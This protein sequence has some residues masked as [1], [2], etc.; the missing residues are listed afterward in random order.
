MVSVEARMTSGCTDLPGYGA[1]RWTAQELL[2]P[3]GSVFATVLDNATDTN[4]SP[5]TEDGRSEL[6]FWESMIA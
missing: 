2:L 3:D 1:V 6:I 4:G 5:L